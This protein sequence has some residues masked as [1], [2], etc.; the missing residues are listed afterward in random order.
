MVIVTLPGSEYGE[1]FMLA[2]HTGTPDGTRARL[3]P[4]APESGSR[5]LCGPAGLPLAPLPSCETVVM[6]L[7]VCLE[8]A[9]CK[10]GS[11]FS[12]R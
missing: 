8:V 3:V 12:Q 4:G 6:F 7:L 11:R 5:W 1:R 2:L 9:R 10:S